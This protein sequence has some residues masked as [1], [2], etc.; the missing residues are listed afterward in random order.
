MFNAKTMVFKENNGDDI[1]LRITYVDGTPQVIEHVVDGH[2]VTA[3]RFKPL[4]DS[5]RVC[6]DTERKSGLTLNPCLQ[7]IRVFELLTA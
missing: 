4:T 1:V 5:M 6:L 7:L 2:A 3:T